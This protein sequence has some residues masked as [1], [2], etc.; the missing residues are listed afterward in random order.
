V[1][2]YGSYFAVTIGTDR[3][4]VDQYNTYWSTVFH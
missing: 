3:E 1:K 4:T 2:G